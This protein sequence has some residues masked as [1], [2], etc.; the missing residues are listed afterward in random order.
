[1]Q[2][3]FLD[4]LVIERLRRRQI[5]GPGSSAQQALGERALTRTG[6]AE[7]KSQGR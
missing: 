6:A 7:H 4:H 5:D 3:D 2:A 1:M